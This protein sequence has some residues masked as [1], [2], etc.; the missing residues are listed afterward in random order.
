MAFG[1]ERS[2][3]VSK[4]IRPFL[5][6]FTSIQKVR[7][8]LKEHRVDM[9][10]FNSP[11]GVETSFGFLSSVQDFVV[12]ISVSDVSQLH[13]L[14]ERINFRLESINEF[15]GIKMRVL[16]VIFLKKN[17]PNFTHLFNVVIRISVMFIKRDRWQLR[18]IL[19]PFD[20]I[21]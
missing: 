15:A 7:K 1:D 20:S 8:G 19:Q 2:N 9:L 16:I 5:N 21:Y 6:N 3:A 18:F 11:P 12:K 13:V 17:R 10:K 14:L 4:G